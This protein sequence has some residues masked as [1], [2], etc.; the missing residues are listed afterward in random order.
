MLCYYYNYSIHPGWI[1]V[2]VVSENV[3]KSVRSVPWFQRGSRPHPKVINWHYYYHHKYLLREWTTSKS[4]LKWFR[5]PLITRIHHCAEP[6]VKTVFVS[7]INHFD[8]CREII[9]CSRNS[10][11]FAFV[12]SFQRNRWTKLRKIFVI[13]TYTHTW[14]FNGEIRPRITQFNPSSSIP[15]EKRSSTRARQTLWLNNHRPRVTRIKM[16]RGW[17]VVIKHIRHRSECKHN[18]RLIFF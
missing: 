16:S 12:H 6:C 11:I 13:L 5:C 17:E 15:E 18:L 2:T 14:F 4:L 1:S 7:C 10:D 9:N 8:H 3:V